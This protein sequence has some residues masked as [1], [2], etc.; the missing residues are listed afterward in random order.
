MV[1]QPVASIRTFGREE[2]LFRQ[3]VLGVVRHYLGRAF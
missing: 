1:N 3:N 2:I